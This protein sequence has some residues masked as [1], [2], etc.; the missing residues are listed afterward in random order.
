MA[1][2][3]NQGIITEGRGNNQNNKKKGLLSIVKGFCISEFVQGVSYSVI[4]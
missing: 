3:H 4:K 2:K 1:D